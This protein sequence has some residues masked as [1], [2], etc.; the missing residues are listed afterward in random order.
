MFE[1]LRRD[2]RV[3]FDPHIAHAG[4]IYDDEARE[5]LAGVHERYLA[6]GRHAG[7]PMIAFADTWRASASRVAASIFAGRTVNRD[8]VEF[9][10][11]V[12]AQSGADVI[13]GALTGP[14][15]DAYDPQQALSGDE[16]LRYH[17]GQI[18]ELAAANVDLI[19]AATLPSL[20][21]AKAIATLLSASGA[22]WMVSFVVRPSGV[23]LD[24]TPLGDAINEIDDTVAVPSIGYSLNC[25]HPDIARQALSTLTPKVRRRL[26]AFQGNT[27]ARTPEELDNLPHVDS[28]D[29]QPFAASVLE[30]MQCSSVRIVGGCCGT[31]ASHIRALSQRLTDS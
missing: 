27:S 30:L 22:A 24:A 25:V 3:A 20:R 16:A 15:G 19:V 9:L 6:I 7:L 8:N 17:A 5:L 11:G 1:L 29:P 31:D 26:I 23:L 4:L 18:A 21:E 13:V 28:T 14:A 2:P 10:R 12:A